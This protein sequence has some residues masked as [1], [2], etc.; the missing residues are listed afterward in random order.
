MTVL[1]LYGDNAFRL[2]R[3]LRDYSRFDRVCNFTVGINGCRILVRARRTS[4]A[5]VKSMLNEYSNSHAAQ[6]AFS[7]DSPS[8]RKADPFPIPE[9]RSLGELFYALT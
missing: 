8:M 7:K 1:T 3:G 2:S 5:G 6:V 9:L 4:H